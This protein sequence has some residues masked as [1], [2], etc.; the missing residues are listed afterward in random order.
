MLQKIICFYKTWTTLT[1]HYGASLFLSQ[2]VQ[3][4]ATVVHGYVYHPF[5]KKKYKNISCR[6]HIYRVHFSKL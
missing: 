6:L 2:L 5:L 4:G 1:S 3:Y